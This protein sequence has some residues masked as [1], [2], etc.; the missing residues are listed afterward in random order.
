MKKK[1]KRRLAGP[2]HTRGQQ[3]KQVR[4]AKLLTYENVTSPHATTT[5]NVYYVTNE[6]SP[7]IETSRQQTSS[8]QRYLP[9]LHRVS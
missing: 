7:H 6:F 1:Q 4:Q 9:V 2:H 8:K 5:T 3:V